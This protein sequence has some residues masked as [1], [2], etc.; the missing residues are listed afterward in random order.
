VEEYIVHYQS[1]KLSRLF[2]FWKD[3]IVFH[4]IISKEFI[5]GKAYLLFQKYLKPNALLYIGNLVPENL[6]ETVQEKITQVVEQSE[7]GTLINQA[8]FC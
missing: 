5:A 3:I 4:S 1:I 7:E 6:T 2:A 8:F